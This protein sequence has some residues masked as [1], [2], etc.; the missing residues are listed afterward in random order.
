MSS[1]ESRGRST[2]IDQGADRKQPFKKESCA[3]DRPERS[4]PRGASRKYWTIAYRIQEIRPCYCH[5]HS[6]IRGSV[7]SEPV[8]GETG[9][10]PPEKQ[11]L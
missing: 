10:P 8:D 1:L 11:R 3:R 4:E 6:P 2:A 9:E 7:G 5:S